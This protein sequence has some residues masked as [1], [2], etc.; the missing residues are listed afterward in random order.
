[1][2]ATD[3]RAPPARE[4]TIWDFEGRAQ[5]DARVCVRARVGFACAV[6]CGLSAELTSDERKRESVRA[7]FA[8]VN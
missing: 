7:G 4:H 2:P 1:M 6:Y 3:P 8:R 5:D